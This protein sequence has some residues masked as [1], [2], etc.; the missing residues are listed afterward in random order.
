MHSFFTFRSVGCEQS[1]PTSA[2]VHSISSG[3][4]L[5]CTDGMSFSPSSSV[6]FS[7]SFTL[8]DCVATS[9]SSSSP[10]SPFSLCVGRGLVAVSSFFSS[11]RAAGGRGDEEEGGGSCWVKELCL[12]GLLFL[13]RA[14][15]TLFFCFGVDW[16]FLLRVSVCISVAGAVQRRRGGAAGAGGGRSGLWV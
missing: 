16:H 15:T 13:F 7:S 9:F 14:L 11:S 2:C 3:S 6:F 1:L 10:N 12:A 4:G 5:I 8:T